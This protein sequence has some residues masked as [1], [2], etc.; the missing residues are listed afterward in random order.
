MSFYM[1]MIPYKTYVIFI[2]DVNKG[3]SSLTKSASKEFT[4][5]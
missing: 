4:E 5:Y 3:V 1:P 2:F